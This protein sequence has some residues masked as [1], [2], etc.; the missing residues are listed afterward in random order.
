MKLLHLA[1]LH[2]GMETYGRI[3]PA[4][5]LNSRLHDFLRCLDQAIDYALDQ[6]IDLAIFAGDAYRSRE[7][8]PTHQREFAARVHRLTKNEIPLVLVVGNHD[9]PSSD[10]KANALEVFSALEVPGV[11]VIRWPGVWTIKTRVG[12]VQIAGIPALAKSALRQTEEPWENTQRAAVARIT[13]IIQDLISQLDSDLP[14]VL[15]AHLLVEGAT[16]SSEANLMIGTEPI[17]PKSVIAHP[18][19]D[20]VALGHV[21]KFQDLNPGDSPPLVY[22]GSVDRVDFGEEKD[23]KGFLVVELESGSARYQFIPTSARRFLTIKVAIDGADA[24]GQVLQAIEG[25]EIADAVVRVMVSMSEETAI[26]E[27]QVRK[28]LAEASF[29]CPIMKEIINPR[30]QVRS[31]ALADHSVDPLAALDEY[32]K[33]KHFSQRRANELREYAAK[34]LAEERSLELESEP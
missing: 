25:Q 16:L 7:P 9:L 6:D 3:D 19:F 20:Y 2:L 12:P 1:D 15:A 22:A 30:A 10:A 18:A 5:G 23:E 4:T 29:I 28:A 27:R 34:L 31:P 17:I 32:L 13:Q 24:T 8:S 11:T 21:H 33:T 26:D 14:T